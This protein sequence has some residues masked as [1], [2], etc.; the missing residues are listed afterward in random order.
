MPLT[1]TTSRGCIRLKYNF[2]NDYIPFPRN[3]IYLP[4][5]F[6]RIVQK[7]TYN[8]ITDWISLVNFT[9]VEY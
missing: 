4:R 9:R 3:A 8:E 6:R 2:K 7:Y 5:R 1:Y